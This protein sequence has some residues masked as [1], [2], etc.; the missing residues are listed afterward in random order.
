L[1]ELPKEVRIPVEVVLGRGTMRLDF[2]TMTDR[3]ARH[4]EL[5]GKS[6]TDKPDADPKAAEREVAKKLDDYR[7]ALGF[8]GEGRNSV[9]GLQ[10]QIEEMSRNLNKMQ[11]DMQALRKVLQERSD[12]I[13]D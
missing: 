12:T 5:P 7:G 3:G 11:D 2:R 9:A 8:F 13:N 10:K 4:P 1:N 6:T